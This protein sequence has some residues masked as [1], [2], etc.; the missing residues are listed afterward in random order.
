MKTFHWRKIETSEPLKMMLD[1]LK[2]ATRPLTG[3]EIQEEFRR[4]GKYCVNPGTT[5]GEL[6]HNPGYVTRCIR[7]PLPGDPRKQEYRYVLIEAPG[8]RNPVM[9]ASERQE[10]TNRDRNR[11][12]AT[13]PDQPRQEPTAD[14][15]RKCAA[16]ECKNIVIR[17]KEDP[18]RMTCSDTC[19][20]AW[21]KSLRPKFTEE[22][23][24]T[25]L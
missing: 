24:G 7:V 3:L 20:E 22:P 12:T 17:S 8:Y 10:P 1:I 21:R 6:G 19:R 9:S 11:P 13:G 5:V 2:S 4:R 15:P 18:F 16:P 23:Q 25:L 14:E